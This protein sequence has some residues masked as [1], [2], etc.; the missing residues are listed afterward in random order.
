MGISVKKPDN[1]SPYLPIIINEHLNRKSWEMYLCRRKKI[2]K[3]RLRKLLENN[4]NY[5]SKRNKYRDK[6]QNFKDYFLIIGTWLA[7]IGAIAL[8]TWEIIKTFCIDRVP[9]H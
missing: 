2:L 1:S 3:N 8:V 7:G 4:L 9:N 6:I 5:M